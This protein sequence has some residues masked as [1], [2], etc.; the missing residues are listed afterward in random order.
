MLYIVLALVVAA[1][2]LL[3]ASLVTKITLLA[4]A[5]LG[6]SVLAA[7]GL[8]VDW[9]LRRRANRT[10]DE[11]D[12]EDGSAAVRGDTVVA[13]TAEVG[14]GGSTVAGAGSGDDVVD[15]AQEDEPVDPEQEPGEEDTDAADLL[16][17][18]ESDDEVRVVD[19]RPRYHR[20]SCRWLAS[21]P[22]LPLPAREARELGFTP[23]AVCV[24]DA[25]IARERR[26]RS[27]SG[28]S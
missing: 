3:I 18:S 8:V 22:T 7:I 1:F 14:A 11:T 28:Q 20:E 4:W 24:P 16:V 6:V 9:A 12:D 5:S 19:E 23:C 13:G 2:G 21:R 25:E 27:A 17:V 26:G 15:G 10:G